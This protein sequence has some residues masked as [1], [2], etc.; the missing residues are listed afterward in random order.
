VDSNDEA[1]AREQ[2]AAAEQALSTCPVD[3][4]ACPVIRNA[5]R[6]FATAKLA[7]IPALCN[8]V[9]EVHYNLNVGDGATLAVAE[10]FSG[11]S[12]VRF[13]RRAMLMI[14]PSLVTNVVFD[15]DVPGT[16]AY[17][18][19]N[20]MA[21][22][23][24]FAV[25]PTYEGYPG[26]SQP[27]DGKTVDATRILSQMATMTTWVRQRRVVP[28]VDLLGASVG[29]AAAIA[30]GG[31]Q[32][33]L[34]PYAVHRIIVSTQV[35]KSSPVLD[36]IF[37]PEFEAFLRSIPGGY[38][39]T[40]FDFYAPVIGFADPPVIEWA[41]GAFPGLY[42]VGPTLDAFDLPIF[43]AANGRA[44]LR[45]FWGT[46]DPLTPQSDVEQFQSEYGGPH[47]LVTIEGA[48]H[49]PFIEPQRDQ[50]WDAA[51]DFV[52]EDEAF[53]LSLCDLLAPQ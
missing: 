47:D 33:P 50:F 1:A 13:P 34:G 51:I 48:G 19:L 17:N 26:S 15:A 4:P 28:R 20:R 9:H 10:K 21:N 2:V 6:A 16:D 36:A 25:A 8:Q 11:R 46:L 43:E 24:F 41:M 52:N 30:L 23:G 53:S 38:L 29:A 39:P 7:D 40:G 22:A 12:V 45:Q 32:S 18:S 14:P 37:T 3:D 31:D 42:A 49:S 5:L 44:P 27:A 35:Y